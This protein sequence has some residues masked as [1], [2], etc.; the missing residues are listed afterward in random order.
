M[1]TQKETFDHDA[2]NLADQLTV[3]GTAEHIYEHARKAASVLP[4]DKAV[5]YLTIASMA[6]DFR[7]EFMREHFPD[8]TELDWCL[9]KAT[10]TLRQRVYESTDSYE[11][12]KKINEI[13]STMMEH[14]FGVDLSGCSVC[15][16]E[17]EG[18]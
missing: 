4:E 13:W 5:F 14:I 3:V 15:R 8:V 18:S 10:D 6:R 2:A 17:K 12:N 16:A 7:R 11:A 9:I 1:D